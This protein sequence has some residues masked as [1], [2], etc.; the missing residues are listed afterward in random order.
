VWH[1]FAPLRYLEYVALLV[2]HA[3]GV[4]AIY[5]MGPVNAG[6]P[7]LFVA[8]LLHKPLVCKVVGDY[9][10]EQGK[11]RFGVTELPEEFQYKSYGWQV[12]VLRSIEHFVA[13]HARRVI[14]PSNYLRTIVEQW[15]VK[16]ERS[17]VIYNAV[18]HITSALYTQKLPVDKKIIFSA[19]RLMP[20]KGMDTLV[21]VVIALAKDD[22]QFHLVIAGDGP[23]MGNLKTKIQTLH[24][25]ALV[26]LLGDIP[27]EAVLDI[28]EHHARVFVLNS[29]YEG[30]SHLL[31]EALDAGC[32]TVAS[33]RGGN[34]EVIH[35]EKT[36][37]LV[38]YNDIPELCEAVRRMTSDE[39]LRSQ[40]R[41]GGKEL[42]KNMSP[43]RM[44][45]ETIALLERISL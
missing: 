22:S 4:D 6:L 36:G 27:H 12:E 38:S 35:N 13:R 25:E 29:G 21:D 23:Q 11:A 32:P 33:N 17:V 31:L 20:W 41:Q 45:D 30:L 16:S 43:E 8:W 10:W 14:V 15:G 7:A 9:A 40:C 18:D 26:T 1:S 2:W 42:V 24:A 3:W 19:G 39:T 44:M 5:A 37:L 34:P 28:F